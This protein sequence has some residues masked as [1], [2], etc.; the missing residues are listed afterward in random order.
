MAREIIKL[1]DTILKNPPWH[2]ETGAEEFQ[3]AGGHLLVRH[4]HLGVAVLIQTQSL[5]LMLNWWL[6][7]LFPGRVTQDDFI[8]A[9][10]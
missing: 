5:E 7:L 2:R 6:Q 1:K 4:T 8:D 10:W 9:A 3:L